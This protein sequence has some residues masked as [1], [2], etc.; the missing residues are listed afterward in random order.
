[1][2]LPALWQGL[3]QAF[4]SMGIMVGASCNGALQDK[5]GRKY[6]FSVSGL[7]A[8]IGMLANYFSSLAGLDH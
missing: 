7:I 3:W 6:M 4:N 1:M 5:F 2:I 8:A